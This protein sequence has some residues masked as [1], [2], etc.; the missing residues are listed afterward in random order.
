[1]ETIAPPEVL[2]P[3]LDSIREAL[4]LLDADLKILKANFSFYRTFQVKPD[5]TE[6]CLIYEIGNRQ[7]DIP[8]L[9]E[10]LEEIL[11]QNR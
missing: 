11:L 4:L 6:G 3:F 5:E 2:N 7:W 1:M 10:L 9:K 8:K